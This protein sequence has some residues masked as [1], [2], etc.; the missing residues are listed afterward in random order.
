MEWELR[1]EHD[2]YVYGSPVVMFGVALYDDFDNCRLM[3][4][5]ACTSRSELV[6]SDGLTTSPY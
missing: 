6:C 2:A 1:N 3:G 4:R 5:F